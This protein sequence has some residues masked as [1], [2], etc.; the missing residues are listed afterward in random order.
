MQNSTVIYSFLLSFFLHLEIFIQKRNSRF[1]YNY[2]EWRSKVGLHLHLISA[3]RM[4]FFVISRISRVK[5]F[6]FNQNIYHRIQYPILSHLANIPLIKLNAFNISSGVYFLCMGLSLALFPSFFL[7]NVKWSCS[8]EE[9]RKGFIFFKKCRV[10][11]NSSPATV[12]PRA[13]GTY[14]FIMALAYDR[15]LDF[16]E[17]GSRLTNAKFS[18]LTFLYK[19]LLRTDGNGFHDAIVLAIL[20]LIVSC[21]PR[22]LS[23]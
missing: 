15:Q 7:L 8:R 5:L 17:W 9:K 11:S 18:T 21:F 14:I 13:L 22:N 12:S 2:I 16:H 1:S 4:R 3:I 19:F 10:S 6:I 23:L 20:F